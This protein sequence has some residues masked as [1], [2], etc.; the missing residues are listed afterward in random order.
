MIGTYIEWLIDWLIDFVVISSYCYYHPLKK[1]HIDDV[2]VAAVIVFVAIISE[3]AV[4]GITG[5]ILLHGIHWHCMLYA[6]V[7][8]C[9]NLFVIVILF[10]TCKALSR[11]VSLGNHGAVGNCFCYYNC[12][13]SAIPASKFPRM[14]VEIKLHARGNVNETRTVTIA[15]QQWKGDHRACSDSQEPSRVTSLEPRKRVCSEQDG[16]RLPDLKETQKEQVR[17][18]SQ[19]HKTSD[20]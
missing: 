13:S 1:T 20:Q 12:L 14:V 9:S 8:E 4:T 6:S 11:L 15:R 18:L 3:I 17:S 19:P 5:M 10:V 7:F 2:V 16:E